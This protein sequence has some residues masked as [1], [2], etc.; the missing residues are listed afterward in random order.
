MVEV[1]LGLKYVGKNIPIH[2][3]AA[4]VRG[5]IKY[6]GDLVLDGMLVAKLLFSPL[7]HAKI[8]SIDATAALAIPGVIGVYTHE[9]TPKTLYNSQVWFD[10]QETMTLEDERIFS[11][12]VRFVGDKVAAVLA[13]DEQTAQEALG[14]IKVKYEAL[15]FNV[16]PEKAFDN[17][18]S[19]HPVQEPFFTK[20]FH[21]GNSDEVFEQAKII[22]EDRV[23]TP[24]VHHAAM[25][26]HV[27]IA[28]P[29]HNGKIT[30]LTPCQIMYSVRLTVAK[31]LGLP[32]NKVRVIKT[33]MG[34]SFGG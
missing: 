5:R 15:P 10:G 18:V 13:V 28:V 14:L 26:P 21:C 16:D 3:G 7:P 33:P 32:F 25:E 34:G 1:G 23:E 8:L 22:V 6:T 30:I 24:K 31:V 9:N 17:V 2:D 19:I 12:T 11:D 4:K 27:C 29:D 20:E